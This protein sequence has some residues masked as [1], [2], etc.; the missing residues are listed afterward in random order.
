MEGSLVC[1]VVRGC[2]DECSVRCGEHWVSW[3]GIWFTFLLVRYIIEY[4]WLR[5][6]WGCAAFWGALPQIGMMGSRAAV[7]PTPYDASFQG[8]KPFTRCIIRDA[9][10]EYAPTSFSWGVDCQKRGQGLN[11]ND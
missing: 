6:A 3:L 10:P 7:N 4:G 1:V 11:I 2:V 9:R 8:H 5:A